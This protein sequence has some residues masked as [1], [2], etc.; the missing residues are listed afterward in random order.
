[1]HQDTKKNNLKQFSRKLACYAQ[2]VISFCF[3]LG[4]D[5]LDSSCALLAN[6]L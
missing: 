2:P 5:L 1:M 3:A 4:E 6:L